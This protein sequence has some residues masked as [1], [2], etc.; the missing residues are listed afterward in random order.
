MTIQEMKEKKKRDRL[1]LF[2]DCGVIRRPFGHSPEDFQ[3]LH[4]LTALRYAAGIGEV[5]QLSFDEPKKPTD[6]IREV[7]APYFVKKQGAI[8][9]KIIMPFRTTS[10]W[11]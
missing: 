5:F 10:V 8:L 3:R 1:H 6:M 2:T 7:S 11:N 4:I 9:W